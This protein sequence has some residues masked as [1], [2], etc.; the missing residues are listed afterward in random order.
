MS[1]TDK[2]TSKNLLSPSIDTVCRKN[3]PRLT[4]YALGTSVT[5]KEIFRSGPVQSVNLPPKI[6]PFWIKFTSDDQMPNQTGY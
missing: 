6:L 5:A 4:R 1:K 3:V 2:K